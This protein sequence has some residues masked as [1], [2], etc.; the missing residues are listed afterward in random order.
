MIKLPSNMSDHVIITCKEYSSAKSLFPATRPQRLAD[1][2]N[3][4][5]CSLHL[6]GSAQPESLLRDVWVTF[7]KWLFTWRLSVSPSRTVS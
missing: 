5:V 2:V 1:L 4:A 3:A 6:T 7:E